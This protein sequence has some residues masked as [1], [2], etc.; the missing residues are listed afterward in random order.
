MQAKQDIILKNNYYTGKHLSAENMLV[1][2]KYYEDIRRLHN[3]AFYGKGIVKGLEVENLGGAEICVR[4]GMAID[5]LGRELIVA[6]P[7][8]VSLTEI[9]ELGCRESGCVDLILEYEEKQKDREYKR[10]GCAIRCV[11]QEDA[12]MYCLEA[13]VFIG[14]LFYTYLAGRHYILSIENKSRIYCEFAWKQGAESYLQPESGVHAGEVKIDIPAAY[15]KG[16]TLITE[17]IRHGFGSTEVYVLVSKE[18]RQGY[19]YEDTG[20]RIYGNGELFREHS[21]GAVISESAVR[22]NKHLGVFQIGIRLREPV[23]AA[24][25]YLHWIALKLG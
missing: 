22:V 14:R 10:V 17:E 19:D 11:E 24:F 1:E 12:E 21:E 23:N 15:R 4:A 2:Q 8:R 16:D 18:E 9:R 5:G 3:Q 6:K 13:G 25:V 20:R 7:F